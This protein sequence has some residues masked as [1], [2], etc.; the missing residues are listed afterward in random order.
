MGWL[1]WLLV[2]TDATSMSP[3]FA[4]GSR[5]KFPSMGVMVNWC[6]G[7]RKHRDR[8]SSSEL[9][10]REIGFSS[11]Y[12]GGAHWY[13]LI[14]KYIQVSV[15]GRREDLAMLSDRYGNAGNCSF[16]L[17]NRMRLMSK[18]K[19]RIGMLHPSLVLSNSWKP[20]VLTERHR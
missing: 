1:L 17:N 13:V 12:L 6:G 19:V 14:S 10:S 16:F 9:F 7:S 8:A 2:P 20:G 4:A 18:L 3:L 15:C 11:T 5:E